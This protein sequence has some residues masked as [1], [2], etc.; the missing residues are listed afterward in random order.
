MTRD[1]HTLSG[2]YALDALSADEAAEFRRHLADCPAC[3][4]EVR[5]LRE[6]AA[7]MGAA[8]ELA[9]PPA[10]KRRILDAA[11]RTPQLPPR[12]HDGDRSEGETA[13]PAARRWLVWVAG[14]A[15][16]VLVVGGGIIGIRAALE[17]EQPQLSAAA[18]KVFDARDAQTQT[19]RTDNGGRL[20]VGVSP[21]QGEMAVD[22]RDLPHLDAQ[23]VYQLWA[24]SRRDMTSAAVLTDPGA[25]AAMAVPPAGTQ[26]AM[27]IE[28][29]GGSAQPTTQPIVVVDPSSV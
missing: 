13:Q 14:A 9:P 29:A 27:T 11:D 15:A 10:L 25:G 7:R 12:P 6:A 26:V 3:R 28:P 8:E 18:T 23:H 5:E 4:D 16:A 21:S 1:V 24:V 17:P 22:S 2:A 20:T 19:V